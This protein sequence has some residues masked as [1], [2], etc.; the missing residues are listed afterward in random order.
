MLQNRLGTA[1]QGVD[2]GERLAPLDQLGMTPNF[3]PATVVSAFFVL[4]PFILLG[5]AIMTI[6]G[7]RAGLSRGGDEFTATIARRARSVSAPSTN[8]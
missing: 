1:E 5:A 7:F 2:L 6:A 4:A 8:S 3:G